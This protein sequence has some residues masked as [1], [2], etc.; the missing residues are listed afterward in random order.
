M[1]RAGAEA[2]SATGRPA[3]GPSAAAP[4]PAPV[5]WARDEDLSG[6]RGEPIAACAGGMRPATVG[7]RPLR[8]R[9]LPC[10]AAAPPP[11]VAV[12]AVP[13]G[14]TPACPPVSRRGAARRMQS[15]ATRQSGAASQPRRPRISQRSAGGGCMR[16]RR[17]AS[18]TESRGPS[19]AEDGRALGRRARSG[20]NPLNPPSAQDAIP[21]AGAAAHPSTRP[22]A[23]SATASSRGRRAP[24][25]TAAA[26][27][28][29][30]EAP[31]LGV[32]GGRVDRGAVR[33]RGGVVG[34]GHPGD[35]PEAPGGAGPA[36]PP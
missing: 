8:P 9:G 25:G 4:V 12:A 6:G 23:G 35:A 34:R 36:L 17:P 18:W 29:P 1:F 2:R 10:P 28:A 32:D 26:P 33:R 15:T 7:C 27:A 21:S 5:P 19:L 13:V 22:A 16:G 24:A 31:V 14:P 20:R 11:A 30:G 3:G